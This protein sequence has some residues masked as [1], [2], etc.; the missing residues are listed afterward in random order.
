MLGPRE[1]RSRRATPE[2]R[3]PG[4]DALV[5]HSG[6][7]STGSRLHSHSVEPG[8]HVRGCAQSVS[9]LG[10]APHRP[11]LPGAANLRAR[12]PLALPLARRTR[13]DAVL[14]EVT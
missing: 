8:W 6:C 9:P 12:R 10:T 2:G 14:S 13:T 11:S 4:W 7:G 3:A 5:E 1:T